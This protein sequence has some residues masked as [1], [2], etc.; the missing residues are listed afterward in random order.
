[1]AVPLSTHV[2]ESLYGTAAPTREMVEENME[3]FND[4]DRGECVY[5]TVYKDGEPDELFFAGNSYD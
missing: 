2:L 1:M 4:I 3:F 5:F